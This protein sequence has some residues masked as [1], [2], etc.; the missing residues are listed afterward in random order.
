MSTDALDVYS[1]H[2]SFQL[3]VSGHHTESAIIDPSGEAEQTI[4]GIY[5]NH[6]SRGSKDSGNAARLIR[7]P[8]FVTADALSTSFDVYRDKTIYFPYRSITHTIE[9][10]DPDANGGSVL[11]LY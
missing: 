11:W 8:R 9:R 4:Y 1:D 5:D 2:L 3:G 6:A 10:I 7:T